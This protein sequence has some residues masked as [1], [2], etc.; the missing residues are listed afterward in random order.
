MKK[1]LI[2]IASVLLVTAVVGVA[3]AQE[4]DED[5]PVVTAPPDGPAPT[6]GSP[7]A[8][9]SGA[10]VSS[11]V[12]PAPTPT[13]EANV[14]G[15]PPQ[16]VIRFEFIG[17]VPA[18]FDISRIQGRDFH[19][20]ELPTE[21]QS[22]VRSADRPNFEYIRPTD[23]REYRVIEPN[24][25]QFRDSRPWAG[26]VQSVRSSTGNWSV[27]HDRGSVPANLPRGAEIPKVYWVKYKVK[28]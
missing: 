3:Y 9:A 25:N 18:N 7:S 17:E 28:F 23:E 26:L 5:G 11:P 22:L 19:F 4:A 24:G 21:F 13:S 6:A 27:S 16:P 20:G 10:A 15:A 8:P 12:A 1:I 2:T 14:A